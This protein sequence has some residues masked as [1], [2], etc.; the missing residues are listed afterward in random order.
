MKNYTWN[1]AEMRLM[2]I[3]SDWFALLCIVLSDSVWVFDRS[4]LIL[5]VWV[6]SM[7]ALHS[8]LTPGLRR[9]SPLFLIIMSDGVNYSE[10]ILV[11]FEKTNLSFPCLRFIKLHQTSVIVGC[12]QSCRVFRK[13]APLTS[14][15][16]VDIV[17]LYIGQHNNIC[18]FSP[19]RRKVPFSRTF[20][21]HANFSEEVARRILNSEFLTVRFLFRK[22]RERGVLNTLYPS[23]SATRPGTNLCRYWYIPRK[24]SVCHFSNKSIKKP[25]LSVI[26]CSLWNIDWCLVFNQPWPKPTANLVSLKF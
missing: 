11:D 4:A 22:D 18:F 15:H 1:S 24:C 7:G 26:Y 14:F 12:Q 13:T 2:G 25:G 17:Y 5:S 19:F 21:K 16:Q 23:Y 10:H 20:C 6:L 9:H 3:S 8:G